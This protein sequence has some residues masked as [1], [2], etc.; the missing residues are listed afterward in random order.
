MKNPYIS[1]IIPVY[2]AIHCLSQCLDSISN[3]T[4]S[5]YEV[6][7]VDDGSQDGSSEICDEYAKQDKRIIVIHKENGGVS[8]ARNRGIEVC[9]GDY[10][11]FVDSDDFLSEDYIESFF[12]Y[13]DIN[14][15][16]V[17]EGC[18]VHEKNKTRY[19]RIIEKQYGK[20]D[21]SNAISDNELF[22]HGSPYGKLYISSIIKE[23]NIKFIESIHNYEDLLF[24][25]EYLE[26]I[27][28]IKLSSDVGYHY[29][30]FNGVL[31]N[32]INDFESESLLFDEY[33]NKTKKYWHVNG[34]ETN[35]KKYL[36]PLMIRCIK[37][38]CIHSQLSR[39]SLFLLWNRFSQYLSLPYYKCGHNERVI[40][41]L[42]RKKLF[43]PLFLF[44]RFYS[45]IRK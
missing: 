32:R 44:I 6:I 45:F 17:I 42:F 29:N 10:I 25:L 26:Y 1:I 12:K 13:G 3:Q 16:I 23:N 21:F 30:V 39:K 31:H 41:I 27:D 24:F 14:N 33:V 35:T 19:Y 43:L 9:T 11:L 38:M 20:A 34:I 5:N 40:A 4:V 37:A 22:K 7:L 36:W 28:V 15:T 2:N 8:S 18:T